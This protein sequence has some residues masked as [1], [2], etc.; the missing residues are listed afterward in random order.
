MYVMTTK[1][2]DAGQLRKLFVAGVVLIAGAALLIGLSIAIYAKA[3]T[4]F[5]TVTLEAD[6]AGL[7]L[8]KN[9][10]V[11]YNGVLVGQI[12]DI[13]QKGDH[14]VIKLGLQPESARQIP[15]DVEASIM[16]TTLFGQKYVALVAA[17][18]AADDTEGLKDGTVIPPDRVHTTVELGRV[19]SRLFPLLEA[20]RPA[21]LSATL[22]A[23]ASALNG[24]GEALGKSMETLD[25]YLT[26]MNVHLPTLQEDLR[27]LAS[28]ADT[29]DSAAPDLIQTLGN[30]TVT[31]KTITAKKTQFTGLFGDVADLSDLGAKILRDNETDMVKATKLSVPTLALLDKYSPEY[32]CLLR[33]IARYKPI[34]AKT[35]EGGEVKQYI[36]FPT[37]QHRAYDQRDLPE[38]RDTRGPRCYGMPNNPI[39]PWP[40]LD[41]ENGTNVDSPEGSGDSYFP[42]GANPG[43]TFLQDLIKELTGQQVADTSPMTTPGG[44]QTTN[45]LLSRRTGMPTDRIPGLSTLMYA[46]MVPGSGRTA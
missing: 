18:T 46:P 13:G 42:G 45:A 43:P 5:T 10:D 25:S 22:N 41:T 11:R 15:A 19:L 12:R 30:L 32:D 8:P 39:M 16:P 21:D 26:D 33:G 29:Y 9:G 7:Q 28:V 23:L 3:F 36:E 31:S 20:V 24:R 44:R 34:L 37:T 27:L 40:G 2:N 1:D 38:Y 17:G 4:T 35:F 14:A 6:R